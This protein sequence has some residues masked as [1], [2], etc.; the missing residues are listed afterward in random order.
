M[1]GSATHLAI[2][3]L[4]IIFLILLTAMAT[5]RSIWSLAQDKPADTFDPAG[6]DVGAFGYRLTR[7]HANAYEFVP[8]A[9][10]PMLYAVATDRTDITDPLA[11]WF[12]A[13]RIGQIATH[14]ISASKLAVLIRFL[15]FFIPQLVILFFWVAALYRAL[16]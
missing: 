11:F 6:K 8:M 4:A 9:L 10:V 14:L 15:V 7:V 16:G 1:T 5:F 12:V 13:L 3:A 2:L